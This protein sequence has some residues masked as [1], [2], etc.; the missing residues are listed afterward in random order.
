MAKIVVYTEAEV[1]YAINMNKVYVTVR[2]E[3]RINFYGA[4]VETEDGCPKPLID[5][6]ELESEDD[7]KTIF[8]KIIET[9]GVFEVKMPLVDLTL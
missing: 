2:D 3:K 5:F 9:E 4:P 6:F 7:A 8:L 1:D